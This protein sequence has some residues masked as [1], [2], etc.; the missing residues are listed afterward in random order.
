MYSIKQ[1]DE[2]TFSGR[3]PYCWIYANQVIGLMSGYKPVVVNIEAGQPAVLVISSAVAGGQKDQGAVPLK[4]LDA[5]EQLAVLDQLKRSKC[6]GTAGGVETEIVK[7]E[8]LCTMVIS[9]SPQLTVGQEGLIARAAFEWDDQ[10]WAGVVTRSNTVLNASTRGLAGKS[11][12]VHLARLV[13]VPNQGTSMG[14]GLY[15]HASMLDAVTRK[16][17]AA[18]QSLSAPSAP[19]AVALDLGPKFE[20]VVPTASQIEKMRA[21]IEF[22]K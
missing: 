7:A 5:K 8:G 13:T 12:K 15:A 11:E 2:I 19:L 4:S 9:I 18:F 1:I 21:A 14:F 22:R 3:A 17:A 6:I 20:F 10:T 16:A